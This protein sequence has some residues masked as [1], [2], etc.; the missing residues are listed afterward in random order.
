MDKIYI[1]RYRNIITNHSYIGKT[2]NIERRK[3]EHISSAYNPNNPCYNRLWP[4]KIRQYGIENFE[5]SILE[6]TDEGH[7]EKREAYWIKYYNSFEGA[8]YNLTSGGE[9]CRNTQ[10]ILTDKEAKQIIC[11]LRDSDESQYVIASN[12]NISQTLLS[13]I[14]QGLRYRQNNVIYPIRKTYKTFE[15]YSDLIN[16]I[17]NT[18][19]PFTKL[20]EKYG[21]SYSTI[22][23]I[24]EGKMWRQNNL[25]YPLRK[26][27][28]NKEKA[29]IIIDLLKNTN[30]T[31]TEIANQV[32]C[33]ITTVNRINKGISH[34]D[35]NI[36][37]PIR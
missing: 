26:I 31:Q 1:Y 37:Y 20:Q 17:I 28:K 25:S 13:N 8:G 29:L 10:N 36:T 23:K 19:I 21:Y 11:E 30:L 18:T 24:N 6:I 34:Y 4:S 7:F 5:F 3:R 27:D 12:W 22:K 33:N 9:T 14:N 16:D 2:N 32:D 15:E 35:P